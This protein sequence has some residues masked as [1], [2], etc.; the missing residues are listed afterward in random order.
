[1]KKVTLTRRQFVGATGAG[2]V[3]YAAPSASSPDPLKSAF[4]S[5]PHSARPAAYWVWLNGFTDN[6]RLTFELEELKKNGFTGAWILEIG[7]YG[8]SVPAGPPFLGPE[9]VKTI[10]HVIREATRLGLDIG[11]ANASSWNSGG[12]WVTP[13]HASKRLYCSSVNVKGPSRFSGQ[14][15]VPVLP[16][17][18]PKNNDGSPAFLSTVA[19]LAI[20]ETGAMSA[21]TFPTEVRRPTRRPGEAPRFI[22]TPGGGVP[23]LTAPDGSPLPLI[24]DRSAIIDL[25]SKTDEKGNLN[26][27][28]P[29]GK[30]IVLRFVC[31][32]TGQALVHPSPKSQGLIIDH[33]SAAASRMHTKVVLDRIQTEIPDFRNTAFKY[34]YACSYE[35]RGSIWTPGL[36]LEF[37]K[38]RGYDMTPYLPVLAGVLVE[39]EDLSQR[40]LVDF[41]KTVAEVFTENF[42]NTSRIVANGYGLKAVAEA[43]GPGWPLHHVPV[44]ALDALSVM[45]IA[46]GEFWQEGRIFVVKE[47]AS[48]AHVFGKKIVQ[49]EAFTSSRHWLDGPCDLKPMA[50]RAFCEGSNHF[51]WHTMPHQP[52][53]TGRPGWAYHAGTHITPNDTWWTMEKPFTEYLGRCSYLLQQG[54]FV[55]DVCYFYG[56]RGFNFVTEKRVDPSLGFG[57]DYD[58]VNSRAILQRMSVKDGRIVLPDGMSYEILVLPD[59]PDL[60]P[61]VLARIGQLVKDGATISG[62]KPARATGLKNYPA[63]DQS[64]QSLASRIWGP[65]DGRRVLETA[66]G[67]GMVFWG[68]PLKEILRR[69][70]VGPDFAFSCGSGAADLDFIHRRD[71]GTDI[72]FV[73]NKQ[74][75]WVEAEC[76]FRAAGRAPE[77]WDP[78]TG[79]T[80]RPDAFESGEGVTRLSL[81]FPPFGSTFVLFRPGATRTPA[82]P[83][84]LRRVPAPQ[85]ITGAWDVRFAPGLGAPSSKPFTKLYSWTEDEDSGIKYFS[86]IA[87]YRKK[88]D[89]SKELF[90]KGLRLYLDL[91]DVRIIARAR[92]NGKPAG[93]AW[94]QPYRLDVTGVA[95]PGVNEVEIEVANTWA[96][97]LTGD[98]VLGGKKYTAFN[99]RWNPNT[100]LLVSGLLGPVRIVATL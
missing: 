96:N 71:H 4:V 79:E 68:V 23:P 98:A 83:A 63:C 93:I 85:E 5:P 58:Y 62:P 25:T 19:V 86:G 67:K 13:E 27:E 81:K 42:Y 14:L 33:F 11:I 88:F 38:R 46:R 51:V 74:N 50:D 16:E 75:A 78:V 7:A 90:V 29:P 59:I 8:D 54:L 92:F 48:A 1:M 39:S 55:A 99:L 56:Q 94:T 89:L 41:R 80:H 15:P 73:R 76:S 47:T 57:Y 31:A 82:K 28:V 6:R 53:Q 32:G 100:P 91:G 40:F 10:A 49:M 17:K 30:W 12:P 20:P 37:R 44:D 60:E 97:R 61:E 95:R 69:R 77:I 22:G 3:T 26:W 66:Y 9:S 21:Y 84:R 24:P 87:T 72:Y 35:A 65:C 18:A 2:A 52:L 70:G 36:D 45:D 43:G 34:Y 64:V